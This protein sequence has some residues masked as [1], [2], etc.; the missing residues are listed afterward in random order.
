[1]TDQYTFPATLQNKIPP[2]PGICAQCASRAEFPKHVPTI[3]LV[4]C[5]HMLTGATVSLAVERPLWTAWGPIRREEWD[6]MRQGALAEAL[7][8]HRAADPIDIGE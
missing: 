8:K 5:E 6:A 1:M 2:L 7:A 3:V 4:F